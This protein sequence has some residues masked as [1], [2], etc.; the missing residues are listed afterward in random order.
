[1]SLN[2]YKPQ[3]RTLKPGPP[4]EEGDDVLVYQEI[5]RSIG[6]L[7]STKKYPVHDGLYDIATQNA[8]QALG[9]AHQHDAQKTLGPFMHHV[10]A[11]H[12]YPGQAFRMAMK[13]GAL[14][15]AKG[16]SIAQAALW[17]HGNGPYNYGFA[18]RI[19]WP[20][21]P[22]IP[23]ELDC[24]SFSVICVDAAGY[25]NKISLNWEQEGN[26]HSLVALGEHVDMNNIRAGDWVFVNGPDGPNSHMF[27]AINSQQGVSHGHAGFP[28]IVSNYFYP[29]YAV[30][31]VIP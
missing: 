25:R 31:R 5:L 6:Y 12:M 3:P 29:I 9:K 11:A 21:P 22:L 17:Y 4:V 20:M 15:G 18:R 24:S 28:E 13:L 8:V 2:L 23:F 26:T 19:I 30:R 14:Q 27:V 10:I 16:H 1:M 7:K